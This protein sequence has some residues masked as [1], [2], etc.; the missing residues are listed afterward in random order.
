MIYVIE[1]PYRLS[2]MYTRSP[3]LEN[4][5]VLDYLVS[6]WVWCWIFQNF[7]NW[8]FTE[9]ALTKVI[10]LHLGCMLPLLISSSSL[11]L[12]VATTASGNV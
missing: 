6:N 1:A 4:S 7:V 11:L 10:V 9:F 5:I 2:E 12:L 8:G 3:K